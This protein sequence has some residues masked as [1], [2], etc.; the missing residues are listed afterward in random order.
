[1]TGKCRYPEHHMAPQGDGSS[2][3]WVALLVVILVAGSSAAVRTVVTDVMRAAIG[4]TAA[5]VSL[6]MAVLIVRRWRRR[7]DTS[8]LDMPVV[9]VLSRDQVRQAVEAQGQGRAIASPRRDASAYP[10][11]DVPVYVVT[12]DDVDWGG[13]D[14]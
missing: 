1:M 3:A 14:D 7:R 13:R 4:I 11:G 2:L 6:A 12:S 5:A 9:V 10:R 8:V